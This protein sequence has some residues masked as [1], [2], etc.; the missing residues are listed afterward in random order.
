[1]SKNIFIDNIEYTPEQVLT[2]NELYNKHLI[3]L[4]KEKK[5]KEMR[6]D[7]KDILIINIRLIKNLEVKIY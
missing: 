7:K 6:E 4:K 1:M 3:K 5:I 2:N